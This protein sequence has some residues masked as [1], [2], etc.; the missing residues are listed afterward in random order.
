MFYTLLSI[1]IFYVL[2]KLFLANL[3]IG[4]VRAEAYRWRNGY[5]SKVSLRGIVVIVQLKVQFVAEKRA[6]NTDVSVVRALSLQLR[7]A[8]S[9]DDCS[10]IS[11]I[12]RLRVR[13]HVT[14]LIAV[15]ALTAS[16]T[17]IQSQCEV[18]HIFVPPQELFV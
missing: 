7:V 8:Q 4:F 18:L 17:H 14:R 10:E 6:I 2:F 13:I 5:C 16:G 11:A 9:R 15:I 12:N 3:Q 1:Y